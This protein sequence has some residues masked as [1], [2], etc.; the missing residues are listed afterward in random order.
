MCGL[1]PD[2]FERT[3][4]GYYLAL[5]GDTTGLIL[6]ARNLIHSFDSR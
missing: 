3:A 2:Y 1:L 4:L 5:M 6:M